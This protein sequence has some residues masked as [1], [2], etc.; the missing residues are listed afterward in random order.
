MLVPQNTLKWS[1]AIRKI[2]KSGV[3]NP[4]RE[5]IVTEYLKL[6]G[7]MIEEFTDN[8]TETEKGLTEPPKTKKRG[9]PKKNEVLA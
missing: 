1:V 4:T 2:K 8:Q 3:D 5:M 7:I 9:R 6:A